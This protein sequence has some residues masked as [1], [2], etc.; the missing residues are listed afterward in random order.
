MAINN[1]IDDTNTIKHYFEVYGCG[2]LITETWFVFID[3]KYPKFV[4]TNEIVKISE[5]IYVS[6]SKHK[7][8]V[9]LE[10]KNDK[11][12]KLFL[13]ECSEVADEIK[14]KYPNIEIGSGITRVWEFKI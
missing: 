5:E 2:L 4:K 9:C 14:T 3:N 1:E 10:L 11:Y 6:S 13:R 7:R 12:I 8:Y